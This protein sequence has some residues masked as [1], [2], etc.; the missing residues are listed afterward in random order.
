MDAVQ[1]WE[2]AL[3]TFGSGATGFAF[4]G[5]FFHGCFDDPAKLLALSTATAL[6]APFEGHF[7]DG[8]PL[9]KGSVTATAGNLRAWSGMQLKDSYWLV[10]TPGSQQGVTL[11]TMLTIEIATN[12]TQPDRGDGEADWTACDLTTGQT[13]AAAGTAT[14]IT[15]SAL[16]LTR[17]TVLL[18]VSGE[19]AVATKCGAL[20]G[21]VWLPEPGYN[22]HPEG[23]DL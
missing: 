10:I 8:T 9:I 23:P 1:T 15:L 11:S 3:H 18:I 16:E 7:L 2:E 14:T 13:H 21:D 6:A 22:Y 20:P 17:T 19:G 12:G 4:F 5:V